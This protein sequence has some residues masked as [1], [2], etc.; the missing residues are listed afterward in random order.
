MP[1]RTEIAF[2]LVG[3]WIQGVLFPIDAMFRATT[4]PIFATFEFLGGICCIA[5]ALMIARKQKMDRSDES[6]PNQQKT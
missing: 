1:N 4:E 3:L 6:K 5:V 2:Y